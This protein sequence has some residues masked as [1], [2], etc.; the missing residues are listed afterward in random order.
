MAGRTLMPAL[1]WIV[2]MSFLKSLVALRIRRWQS[3]CLV[4]FETSFTPL[5]KDR[6]LS[7]EIRFI[8]APCYIIGAAC[9]T[10]YTSCLI[11]DAPRDIGAMLH[12][13]RTIWH[14][15][16]TMWH[17]RCTMLHHRRIMW[18]HRRTMWHHRRTMW[19]HRCTMLHHR[20]TMWHHRRTMWHHRRSMWHHRRTMLH[21]R[22]TMWQ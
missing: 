20:R 7:N 6:I 18:N 22:R 16:R 21:H 10:I 12:H 5:T 9:S 14:H 13:R 1:H 19:H 4:H 3:S 8:D 17:H 11:S 2:L 15:R